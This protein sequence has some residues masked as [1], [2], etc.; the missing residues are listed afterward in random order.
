M[1]KP[2]NNGFIKLDHYLVRSESWAGLSSHATRLL[3]AI[4]DQFDGRNN[5]RLRFGLSQGV[6]VLHCGRDTAIRTFA[7]LQDAG[8]IEVVDKG[9]FI[10]KNGARKGMATAWRLKFLPEF[11]SNKRTSP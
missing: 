9:S 4:W 2:K 7:E 8:L 1:N 3:I 11:N 10:H 6:Q 5:G